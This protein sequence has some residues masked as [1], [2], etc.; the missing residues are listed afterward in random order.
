VE[1]KLLPLSANLVWRRRTPLS[2]LALACSV[3]LTLLAWDVSRRSLSGRLRDQFALRTEQIA[4]AI[5]HRMQEHESVLR[6]GV[7]LFLA[8]AQVTREEFRL[9]FQHLQLERFHPGI[10]GIGFAELVRASELTSTVER[11]RIPG[12]PARDLHADH[13]HRALS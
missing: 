2:W 12:R 10:Q 8:S 6:G 9:Y 4:G 13:L 7:A 3:L 5:L 1:G 11:V